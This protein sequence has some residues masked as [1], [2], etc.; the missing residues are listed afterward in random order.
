VRAREGETDQLRERASVEGRSVVQHAKSLTI[1]KE[2]RKTERKGG[3]N[4]WSRAGHME[5]TRRKEQLSILNESGAG[6]IDECP[7]LEWKARIKKR[8]G[9]PLE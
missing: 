9:E 3:K 6:D 2:G 7:G 5:G 4:R 8:K 1:C